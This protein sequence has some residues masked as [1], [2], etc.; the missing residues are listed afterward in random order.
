MMRNASVSTVDSP[1]EDQVLLHTKSRTADRDIR[2]RSHCEGKRIPIAIDLMNTRFRRRN[3]TLFA[4]TKTSQWEQ[5]GS[6][7]VHRSTL[8]PSRRSPWP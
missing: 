2:Q 4:S 5:P 3:G 6:T 7:P 1:G 8:G